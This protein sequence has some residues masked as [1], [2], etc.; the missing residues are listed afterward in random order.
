MPFC[1]LATLNGTPS[2]LRPDNIVLPSM[3]SL[4]ASRAFGRKQSVHRSDG[5]S[6]DKSSFEIAVNHSPR[7][8]PCRP[9]DVKPA[10]LSDRLLNRCAVREGDTPHGS[11]RLTPLS[12]TPIAETRAPHQPG[13][14]PTPLDLCAD[15]NCST[16]YCLPQRP[17]SA[18][19]RTRERLDMPASGCESSLPGIAGIDRRL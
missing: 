16:G 5:L 18:P 14:R 2:R 11:T 10:F 9:R 3:R 17:H 6:G 12:A 15:H 19:S 13:V 4:P 7:Q 1:G 8:V